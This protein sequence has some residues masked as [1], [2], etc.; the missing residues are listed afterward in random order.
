MALLESAVALFEKD[1]RAQVFRA[2]VDSNNANEVYIIRDGQ[3]ARD[4]QSYPKLSGLTVAAGDIVLVVRV[5]KGY[6]VVGKIIH[7]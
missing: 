6:V 4:D 1:Q 3:S 2:T 5:G 7:N